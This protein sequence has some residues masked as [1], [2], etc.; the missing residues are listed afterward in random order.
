LNLPNTVFMANCTD[1]SQCVSGH[2]LLSCFYEHLTRT[3]FW[4]LNSV[5][6][7]RWNLLSWAQSIE[8]VPIS[9]HQHQHTRYHIEEIKESAHMSLVDHPISQPNLDISPIWNPI[10]VAED[11][12]TTP[13]TVDSM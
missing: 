13:S 10:I 5:S 9:E 8:L 12:T 6:G 11:K 4:R 3:A 7:F 1:Y 2:Y